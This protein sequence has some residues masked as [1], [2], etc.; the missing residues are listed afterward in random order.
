MSCANLNGKVYAA[1]GSS[2]TGASSA[3]YSSPDQGVKWALEPAS[4]NFTSRY[5][6]GMTVLNGKLIV[7]GGVSASGVPLGDTL[8]GTP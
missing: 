1:G 3:I 4:P 6:Q 2:G 7:V 8:V 5:A